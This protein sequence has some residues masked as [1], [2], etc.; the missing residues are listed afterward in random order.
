[1]K[2]SLILSVL[3]LA[4]LFAVGES[5][6]ESPSSQA[7]MPMPAQITS[8]DGELS[9]SPKFSVMVS[10]DGVTPR[11]ER[12]IWRFLRRLSDRTGIFFD[13]VVFLEIED[14]EDSV[15][16]IV[17]DRPGMLELGEDESYKLVVTSSAIK[18][19]GQ[20]DIGILRGL[21][22][23]L[24]LVDNDAGGYFVPAVTVSDEPR[25]PWRGLMID[26]CR[27]FMP[28]EVVKRNLDGMA[29]V[30][31][32]VLH[33]HLS[34]DQGFRV[35]SL[36][37]PK[38][39]ELGS[40]GFFYTQEQIREVVAYAAD[41]GIRVVPEFDLPGHAT[42][43][44]VGYPELAS[45]PGPYAIERSWGIFDPSMDPTK[46]DTYA[47][48]KT[49][50]TEMAAL[51]P[52]AYM[53][54]GGD[55]N[56]GKHWLANPQIRAFM[57]QNGLEE[58][59]DLQRYF[60]QRLLEILTGIGK[61]MV[62]WDEILQPEL[63][64]NIAIQSWRGRESLYEAA[65]KGYSG[66]LSNGYYIDL[67]QPTDFH[68][69]NDPLPE[70]AP[71][72]EEQKKL[73]LGGEATM[74][75]EFVTP[76]TVDSRIWPRTAA[77]AERLWSPRCVNDVE[78]MYRRL[79]IIS[80]QLEEHG[81]LHEKNR[82]MLLRRLCQCRDTDALE[83]LLGAIEPVKIY[84]R[85]RLRKYTQFSPLTRIVDAA[86]ADAK[87]AREFRWAIEAIVDSG[88]TEPDQLA[89]AQAWL[90]LWLANYDRL[91]HQ[92]K[93]TPS[94]AEMV[95]MAEALKSVASIGLETLEL[96]SQSKAVPA[97]WFEPRLAQLETARQPHGQTELMIVDP[98]H[99]LVCA[100]AAAVGHGLEACQSAA[101]ETK[102]DSGH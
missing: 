44:L 97:T 66:L 62:G 87:P 53:H 91:V 34:E 15:M 77:I 61:Q 48:L 47:F 9:L 41:L 58:P 92:L 20:T 99:K 84:N 82:G 6:G 86:W 88:Q 1:M 98:V 27:H 26:A 8:A 55:E 28:V 60:N 59:L 76:E 90:H 79:D 74:W 7:L 13:P 89:S 43:W 38:L 102:T 56:T 17:A 67:I 33:W 39:H 12:G 95:P 80:L 14:R 49:L 46:E 25:F 37:L 81:L 70:D 45:A 24:Q 32:N 65:K 85:G 63:P 36:A 75:A 52:D 50:F 21:E 35:E 30:K 42:S 11:L 19:S 18:L 16:T 57:D 83:V 68:Y 4:P 94:L 5:T 96:R 22:T 64:T 73:I 2:R 40:D 72:T 51:F 54:I 10:G 3:I 100:T 31:L 78:D 23:V 69:L 93:S 101:D 71:L 29:A